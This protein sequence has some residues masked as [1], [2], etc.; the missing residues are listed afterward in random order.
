MQVRWR[1]VYT[2]HKHGQMCLLTCVLMS[3]RMGCVFTLQPA[4]L[5][6]CCVYG[7]SLV[8]SLSHCLAQ[9]QEV[10]TTVLSFNIYGKYILRSH[11]THTSCSLHST[12]IWVFTH[13][14]IS[15]NNIS[16]VTIS[17]LLNCMQTP[18][19]C[20][21]SGLLPLGYCFLMGYSLSLWGAWGQIHS[22]AL[23]IQKKTITKT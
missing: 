7:V 20:E 11:A 15:N 22:V 14:F 3:I 18:V 6:Y 21:P 12:S 2:D 8:V 1:L 13:S 23:Q 9:G 17:T 10:H 4:S 16:I 19:S 5:Q